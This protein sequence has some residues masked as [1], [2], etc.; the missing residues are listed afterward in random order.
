M[1]LK[2]WKQALLMSILMMVLVIP[3]VGQT[4]DIQVHGLAIG[5][6]ITERAPQGVEGKFDPE[7]GKLYAFTRVVGAEQRTRVHHRWYWGEQLMADVE[8]PV[9]SVSW[10]TWSSKNIDPYWTGTWKVEV[11]GED[12]QILDTIMFAVDDRS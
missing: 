9:Q 12:G 10:R 2:Y 6:N 11:V 7:V 4:E 3:A 5:T 8:L 1:A